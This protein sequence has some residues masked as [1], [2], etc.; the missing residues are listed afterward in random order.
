MSECENC[1]HVTGSKEEG[2]C[3]V[4]HKKTF[5]N[6]S[7]FNY[8]TNLHHCSRKGCPCFVNEETH[9]CTKC[10]NGK[11]CELAFHWGNKA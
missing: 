4:N 6:Y 8:P 3:Y 1:E 11:K 9:C 5:N 10:Y 2:D 7:K